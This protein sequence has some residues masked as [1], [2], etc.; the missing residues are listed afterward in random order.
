MLDKNDFSFLKKFVDDDIVV[1]EAQYAENNG[2]N[3]PE[4]KKDVSF[5]KLVPKS[6][7]ERDCDLLFNRS[8]KTLSELNKS[9][10]SVLREFELLV[11]RMGD[12]D[13]K[14]K[15]TR[16]NSL[17][18]AMDFPRALISL[19]S[20]VNTLHTGNNVDGLNKVR[21]LLLRAEKDYSTLLFKIRKTPYH[22]INAWCAVIKTVQNLADDIRKGL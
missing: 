18:M 13:N 3:H 6:K 5:K 15:L 14:Q 11:P 17:K 20:V 10:M 9:I 8:S 12:T 7:S 21:F 2:V 19:K 22:P 16:L 1:N 4:N